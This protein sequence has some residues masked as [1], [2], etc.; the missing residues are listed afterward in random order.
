[1]TAIIAQRGPR[2][3]SVCS[4]FRMPIGEEREFSKMTDGIRITT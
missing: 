4:R 2:E 3:L 1:M